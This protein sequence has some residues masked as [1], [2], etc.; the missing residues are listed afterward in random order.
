MAVVLCVLLQPESWIVGTVAHVRVEVDGVRCFK[1]WDYRNIVGV[2]HN[3]V[4]LSAQ[5]SKG[6]NFAIEWAERFERIAIP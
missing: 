4:G 3:E 2:R 5:L 6:T 1:G